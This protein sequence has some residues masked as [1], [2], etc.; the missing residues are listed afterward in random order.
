MLEGSAAVNKFVYRKK[1]TLPYTL[2]SPKGTVSIPLALGPHL[3]TLVFSRFDVLQRPLKV[4]PWAL[5]PAHVLSRI[6]IAL[7]QLDQAVDVFGCDSVVLLVEVVDV[8]VENFDEELDAYGGIHASIGDAKSA[9]KTLEHA[10]AVAVGLSL[11]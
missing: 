2:L 6:K 7:D 3:H 1:S 9:L 4:F 5:Q 10:L 8:A 11:C